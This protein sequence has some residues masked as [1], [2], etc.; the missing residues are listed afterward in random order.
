LALACVALTYA[1][2]AQPALPHVQLVEAGAPTANQHFVD[3]FFTG[4]RE[5]GYEQGRNIA[6]DVKWANGQVEGFREAFANVTRAPPDVIVVAST[7]GAR[8]AKRATRSIPIVFIGVADPVRAGLVTSLAAPRGTLTGL[9][10]ESGDG[11]MGKSIEAL[12][13]IAPGASRIALLWNPD[14]GTGDG[15]GRAANAAKLLALTPISFEVRSPDGFDAAFEQMR[16][17][18][19][20][21]LFVVTDP[22]TLANR[23]TIVRLAMMHRIP[24]AY[25]FGEFVRSG[26]L[27]AYAPSITDQF[28]RA[29]GYVDK[30]LRGAQPGTLPIEQPTKYELVVNATTAK[31]LGLNVPKSLLLRADEVIP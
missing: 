27:V 19:V 10:R 23:E 6:V 21:A 1:V 12:T 20:N 18:R 15:F 25:E 14:A 7:L 17:Q 31:R 30:I 3:A 22:L 16:A 28:R 13:E 24:A 5:L 4:L 26:G 11:L 29:A 2:A 8:E 9:V